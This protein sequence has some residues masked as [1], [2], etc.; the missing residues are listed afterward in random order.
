M[1]VVGSVVTV[2]AGGAVAVV[3]I[4]GLISNQVD[5]ASDHPGNANSTTIDYGASR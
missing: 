3:T 2:V 1:T 4:V 5:S